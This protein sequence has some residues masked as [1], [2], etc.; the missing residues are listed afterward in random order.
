MNLR[1][2]WFLYI[3]NVKILNQLKFIQRILI[4]RNEFWVFRNYY[5][6]QFNII[7]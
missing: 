1:V 6:E 5:I 4:M 7:I 3:N 2:K